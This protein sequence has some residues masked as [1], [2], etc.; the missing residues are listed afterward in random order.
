MKQLLR[1]REGCGPDAAA[2]PTRS[3]SL[4]ERGVGVAFAVA[5]GRADSLVSMARAAAAK[6]SSIALAAS[7]DCPAA[8]SAMPARARSVPALRQTTFVPFPKGRSDAVQFLSLASKADNV[9]AIVINVEVGI[10]ARVSR[11]LL[12]WHDTF[13]PGCRRTLRTAPSQPCCRL[14]FPRSTAR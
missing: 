8:A 1:L 6:G 11:R 13:C 7:R 14:C 12:P 10:S 3:S 2:P 4:A 9:K 5:G